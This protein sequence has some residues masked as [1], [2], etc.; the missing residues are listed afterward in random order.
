MSL[1][2]RQPQRPH[3]TEAKTF[4]MGQQQKRQNS[5]KRNSGQQND[6]KIRRKVIVEGTEHGHQNMA[7]HKNGQPRRKIVRADMAE[8]LVAM[9]T[10]G[11]GLKIAPESSP[12]ATP[13][14]A[15]P[16]AAP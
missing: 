16:Q 12:F 14:A 2:A 4:G 10:S 8:R 7:Q 11:N 9:F 15:F 13:G 3:Q 5:A 6:P 1:A